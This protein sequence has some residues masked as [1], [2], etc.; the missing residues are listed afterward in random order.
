MNASMSKARAAS[1]GQAVGVC[2]LAQKIPSVKVARRIDCRWEKQAERASHE[3][4]RGFIIPHNPLRPVPE[5]LLESGRAGTVRGPGS[6]G[7]G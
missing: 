7:E 6:P 1:E 2:R 3:F 4:V 5:R